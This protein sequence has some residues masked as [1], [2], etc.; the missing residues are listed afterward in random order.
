M[1]RQNIQIGAISFAVRVIHQPS[2]FTTASAASDIPCALRTERDRAGYRGTG[3][4][5]DET[6]EQYYARRALREL[7]LAAA[8]D[9][10]GVKAVHLNLAARY[11][12]L[13]EQAVAPHGPTNIPRPPE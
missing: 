10:R 1:I 2:H 4:M 5:A 8:A 7:D 11:A 13:R 12:T 9:D 6:D 3:R